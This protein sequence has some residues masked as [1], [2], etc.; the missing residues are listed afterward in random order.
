M[1]WSRDEC[2][3]KFIAEGG[4]D[5]EIWSARSGQSH[6]IPRRPRTGRRWASAGS[7]GQHDQAV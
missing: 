4:F 5:E 3:K 7:T 6:A 2:G 1:H